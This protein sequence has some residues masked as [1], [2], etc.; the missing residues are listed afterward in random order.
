MADFPRWR[1]SIFPKFENCLRV[2]FC[3]LNDTFLLRSISKMSVYL[4]LQYYD[5]MIKNSRWPPL[6][7]YFMFWCVQPLWI[8]LDEP[9]LVQWFTI[10]GWMYCDVIWVYFFPKWRPF[11]NGVYQKST[12]LEAVLDIHNFDLLDRNYTWVFVVPLCPRCCK[13]W[14]IIWPF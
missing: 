10:L 13:V 5:Y 14:G 6:R 12:Y 9:D 4:I 2:M 8:K 3:D 7:P 1:I 11:Q